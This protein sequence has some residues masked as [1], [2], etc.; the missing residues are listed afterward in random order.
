MNPSTTRPTG[1][2]IRGRG[3]GG[4]AYRPYFYFRR[5]GRTIPAGG[6]GN[7]NAAARANFSGCRGQ[8]RG[9]THNNYYTHPPNVIL[10]STFLRPECYAAPDDSHQAVQSYRADMPLPCPGWYLYF[11]QEPYK[12]ES[13]L[14]QRIKAVEEHYT[15]N[16]NSY[17][18]KQI[19]QDKW[20]KLDAIHVCDDKVLINVWPQLK[21][22]M[23][24]RAQRTLATFAVAMHKVLTMDAVNSAT[25]QQACDKNVYVPRCTLP[26]KIY[27]RPHGFAE[28]N[29]ISD[30]DRSLLGSLCTVRGVVSAIGIVE[31]AAS[32]IAYQCPRCKQEQ[33]MKQNGFYIS[34]PYNCKK[35]GCRAKKN[36]IEQRSSPFTRIT[37]QQIVQLQES[38][39]QAPLD[40]EFDSSNT[41]DVELRYDLVDTLV[42]GEEVIICGVIKIRTLDDEQN[43][44]PSS[45]VYTS[46]IY[47]KAVSIHKAKHSGH[48]FTQRDMDAI[49]MINSEPD[50]FKLLSHSVAPELHGEE[51]VKAGVLLSLFGGAGSQIHDEAEINVLLVGDPGIG[52]S[53]LLEMCAKISDRGTYLSGK[54]WSPATQS[55]TSALQGRTSHIL[56]SGA[57]TISKTGHCAID[58]IDRLAPQQDILLQIMQSKIVSLPFHNLYATMSMPTSLIAAANSLHGHYDHSR[59][60]TENSRLS[61]ALLQHFHLVFLLLD[62]SNK[63]L[64]TSLTDHIK[65]IH[66][67]IKKNTAIAERFDRKPK[68]NNSMNLSVNDDELDDEQ[69]DLSVRLKLKIDICGEEELDLLP[70]ILLKKFIAYARQRLR[71]L[72]NDEAAEALKSFYM[73]LRDKTGEEQRC[74]VTTSHLAGLICLSQARARVDFAEVVTKLHVRDVLCIVRHSIADTTLSDYVDR[75]PATTTAPTS[76]R[77]TVKKFIQMLELRAKALG[78][79]MFNYDEIK[80]MAG[81]AGIACGVS[82]LVEIANLQGYLL[83]K[84]PNVY[85]V[86]ID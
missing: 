52:K 21:E 83:K 22:D 54:H 17:D 67:G 8:G 28:I 2:F 41:L 63:D 51:I 78:R 13:T 66:D 20:F 3:R 14:A 25:S 16:Q 50:S 80:D 36:F 77:G 1:R 12:E 61:T 33:S 43:T 55:L 53:H 5:N 56:T 46:Q 44:N 32:W 34:R 15:K 18:L 45:S 86:M 72:L 48:I 79:C 69:Y 68:T 82:N 84:G 65:A 71:P 57:L 74:N 76:Q 30:L 35:E 49:S 29:L 10:D 24:E 75:N 62:K 31:A 81:Q 27:V 19:Q 9:A 73:S 6:G 59:P 26:R 42:T 23:L 11:P 4:G 64:D 38:N 47:M 7:T 70:P 60:L 58:D 37:P 39:I 85:E 40:R